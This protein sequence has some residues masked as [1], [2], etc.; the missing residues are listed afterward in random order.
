[1]S[2]RSLSFFLNKTEPKK[3]TKMADEQPKVIVNP[4]TPEM[5]KLAAEQV[6]HPVT[7]ARTPAAAKT[8][9]FYNAFQAKPAADPEDALIGSLTV[10]A[11]RA[12]MAEILGGEAK[13]QMS[14]EEQAARISAAI[15]AA[16]SQ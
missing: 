9:P 13:P 4:G 5:Q 14:A 6:S 7:G 15:Q 1:M 3:E 10:H 2:L 16:L 11:F 12:L 8:S